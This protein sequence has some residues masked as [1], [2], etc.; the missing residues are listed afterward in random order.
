MTK[1]FYEAATGRPL[2]TLDTDNPD[3]LARQT[4]AYIE[5]DD[6]DVDLLAVRVMNGV[7]TDLPEKPHPT[8]DFDFA[9]NIW[10]ETRTLE[11]IKADAHSRLTEWVSV[12]RTK[13]MTVLP[14]QEMIYLAKE[15]EAYRYLADPDPDQSTY[16]FIPQEIGI[17]A[18]DA[19]QIAQIWASMSHLW[20]QIAANVESVRL[21]LSAQI[22]AATAPEQVEAALA[23]LPASAN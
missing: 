3:I 19:Y 10:L 2:F 7:L 22:V 18:Q 13:Y 21:R 14:G 12:E 20:R 4:D 16:T 5:I 8:A 17:T 23:D 15:A 11:R 9:Q 6:G 1:L